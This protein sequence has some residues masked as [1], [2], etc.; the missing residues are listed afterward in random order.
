M[1]PRSERGA[2][3]GSGSQNFA[4]WI[5][6]NSILW[7]A[8]DGTTAEKP[9]HQREWC[10]CVCVCVQW[11]FQHCSQH[12][13][14]LK[15]YL[16]QTACLSLLRRPI[17]DYVT[18]FYWEAHEIHCDINSENSLFRALWVKDICGSSLSEGK[19]CATVWALKS[20]P[21]QSGGE[22]GLI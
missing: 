1:Q 18:Y 2:G 16:V 19:A 7:K 4:A 3:R 11:V 10:V 20:S 17:M 15:A 21:L 12:Y 6:K 13:R 5:A 9:V 14:L 22:R 8:G